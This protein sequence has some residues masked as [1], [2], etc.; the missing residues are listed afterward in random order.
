MRD[1]PIIQCAIKIL[2]Q[3]Q[4]IIR[5]KLYHLSFYGIYDRLVTPQLVL[6][7]CFRKASYSYCVDQSN[8]KES[9]QKGLLYLD[10]MTIETILYVWIDIDT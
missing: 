10:F 4:N 7:D 1:F 3:P 6:Q 2:I 8:I 9:E 5:T